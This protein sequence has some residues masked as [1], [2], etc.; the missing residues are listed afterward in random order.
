MRNILFA[1]ALSGN[2]LL[3]FTLDKVNYKFFDKL[4]I[5]YIK[6]TS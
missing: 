1:M 2:Y 3:D 4:I 6:V 5:I